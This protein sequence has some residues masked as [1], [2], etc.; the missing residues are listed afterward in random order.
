MFYLYI[1]YSEKDKRLYVGQTNN[2]KNRLNRHN[3]GL[4]LATKG[5]RPLCLIHE[6]EY[7]TR[8]EAVKREYFLKS[9][10]GAREKKKILE[11]YLNEVR[12]KP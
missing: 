11:T 5:R 12:A 9:L 6:E 2:L 8:R 1:L 4:V 7:Q 10:W 3:L